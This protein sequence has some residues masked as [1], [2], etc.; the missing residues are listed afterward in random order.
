M[1][2]Q[3]TKKNYAPSACSSQRLRDVLLR[4]APA[5][6]ISLNVDK[7]LVISAAN[8]F[9]SLL[10]LRNLTYANAADP[11]K[12]RVY[13]DLPEQRVRASVELMRPMLWSPASDGERN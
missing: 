7:H 9:Q 13:A 12:V 10:C 8:M 4:Y 6:S 2:H 3:K 11:A 1:K 5:P